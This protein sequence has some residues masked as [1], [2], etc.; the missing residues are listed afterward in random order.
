VRAAHAASTGATDMLAWV[1]ACKVALLGAALCAAG[2]APALSTFVPARTTPKGHARASGG[3]GAN[4]PT[5]Q[6]ANFVSVSEDLAERA[7]DADRD[8]KARA[9]AKT[10]AL[11]FNPPSVVG[12]PGTIRHDCADA[13]SVSRLARWCRRAPMPINHTTR[14]G[15]Q[16]HLRPVVHVRSAGASLI[17]DVI[18]VRNFAAQLDVL[19]CSAGRGP[20]RTSARPEAAR[21]AILPEGRRLPTSS[22]CRRLQRA[23]HGGKRRRGRLPPAS[24]A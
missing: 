6:I 17:D 24:S 23:S 4:L 12:N 10:A 16:R 22:G 8:R 15:A 19:S 1:K 7:E 11:L 14:A 18:E 20:S 21:A 13:A 3:V 9:D 2:C 5:G